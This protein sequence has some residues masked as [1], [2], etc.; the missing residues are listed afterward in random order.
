MRTTTAASTTRHATTRATVETAPIVDAAD[1]DPAA[2]GV[3]GDTLG[4][5]EAGCAA[6]GIASWQALVAAARRGTVFNVAFADRRPAEF[7]REFSALVRASGL[8]FRADSSLDLFLGAPTSLERMI[9]GGRKPHVVALASLG[10]V[11]QDES[12]SVALSGARRSA[13]ISY[14]RRPRPRPLAGKSVMVLDD[15]AVSRKVLAAALERAGCTVSAVGE[16]EAAFALLKETR[17]DVVVLDIVL[18]GT[19]DG[20]DFCRAMRSNPQYAN[21]PAIFVTGHTEAQY[22]DRA[23]AVQAS[24]YFDKPVKANRL[25]AAVTQLSQGGH[26]E[27]E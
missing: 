3:T 9:D 27:I 25:C 8:K 17:P 23:A 7:V 12:G 24:A 1:A 19:L 16:A 14:E 13:G 21:I 10:E 15:D 20:F 5:V 11:A 4:R 6:A 26:V 18:G 22:R 2:Y